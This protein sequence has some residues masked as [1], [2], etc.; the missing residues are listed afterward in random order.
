MTLVEITRQAAL[1]RLGEELRRPPF[2]RWVQAR[3]VEVDTAKREITIAVPYR[4]E[5]SYDPGRPIFHGGVIATVADIAGYAVVAVWHGG[6]TPTI[7]LQIDYL[8][9]AEGAE[10]QARAILRKLGRSVSRADIEVMTGNRLVALGRGMFS[11]AAKPS[12]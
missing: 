12:A 5:L 11:T 8:A 4:P 6:S 1:E 10:L 3:P 7:S 2:N 9:P